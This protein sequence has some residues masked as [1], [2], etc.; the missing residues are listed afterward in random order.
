MFIAALF[1]MSKLWKQ[2]RCLL[3]MNE[4]RKSGVCPQWN[5]IQSQRMKFCLSQINGWNWRTSSS[6]KLGRLRRPKPVCSLSYMEYR[7]NTNAAIL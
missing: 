3:L 4:L 2:S 1:T 6:V 5:F 7:L